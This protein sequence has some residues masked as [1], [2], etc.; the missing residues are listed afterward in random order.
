MLKGLLTIKLLLLLAL[1]PAGI[2]FASSGNLHLLV[3]PDDTNVFEIACKRMSSEE[4]AGVAQCLVS[5]HVG[6]DLNPFQP[7]RDGGFASYKKT[8]YL[9][10]NGVLKLPLNETF[11]PLRPPKRS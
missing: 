10:S 8:A 2:A 9:S 1:Q 7:A 5:G 3:A 11:P 6:C 4:C